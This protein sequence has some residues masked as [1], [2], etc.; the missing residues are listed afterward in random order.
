VTE[1]GAEQ[2]EIFSWS[3][4]PEEPPVAVATIPVANGPESLVI[5]ETAGRAYSHRWQ[6]STVAI[7]MKGRQIVEEWATGCAASR[8]I[9]IDAKRRFLFVACSEGTVSVFD[10]KDGHRL[11]TM[12]AGAG[13]DVIGYSVGLG[14]LYLAGSS[15]ACLIV[16]GVSDVGAIG[17][18]GRR[19]APS[20]T[21]CAAADDRGSAWVCDP[22]SGRI[23][24][25]RDPHASSVGH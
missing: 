12:A 8:G 21:H 15:C 17:L 20:G 6:R 22:D 9:E 23:W 7:D 10:L 16:A 2:I 24:R 13:F 14:H 18:L 25:V 11:S 3:G 5:D 4:T 1:P 19:P